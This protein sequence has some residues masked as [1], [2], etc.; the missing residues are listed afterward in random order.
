MA[1]SL[2]C[3]NS[4]ARVI[5]TNLDV[6]ESQHRLCVNSFLDC[7]S[8][9]R[10]RTRISL[11]T[12]LCQKW[13]AAAAAPRIC[14]RLSETRFR[15]NPRHASYSANSRSK[16]R[17]L[18]IT[19]YLLYFLTI[20]RHVQSRRRRVDTRCSRRKNATRTYR[21]QKVVHRLT[22]KVRFF[23]NASHHLRKQRLAN[24]LFDRNCSRS[25]RRMIR[26]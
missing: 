23:R 10:C 18:R 17:I 15:T 16:P 3:L 26:S 21:S 1:T 13:R 7:V 12:M 4:L 14:D 5:C 25:T 9:R 22:K 11:G 2:H 8:H 6:N 24:R 19:Q 20:W